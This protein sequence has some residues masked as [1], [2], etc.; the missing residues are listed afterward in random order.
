MMRVDTLMDTVDDVFAEFGG[1]TAL[2]RAIGVK[3]STASEMKRRQSIPI[4]YWQKL[5]EAARERGLEDL[6]YEKLVSI[7][8]DQR[9]PS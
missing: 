4:D 7:H 6:T 5:T 1:P 3:P 9:V 8:T 2:G